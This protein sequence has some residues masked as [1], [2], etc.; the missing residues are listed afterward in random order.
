MTDNLKTDTTMEE[1][2]LATL[3]APMKAGDVA[4]ATGIDKKDVDK[5]IKKLVAEGKVTSPK[6]CYYEAVK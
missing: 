3:A 2:I 4:A 5:I 6:R 1:K